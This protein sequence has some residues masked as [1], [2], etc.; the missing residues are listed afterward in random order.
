MTKVETNNAPQNDP[1]F[2]LHSFI[3]I[4]NAFSS[5]LSDILPQEAKNSIETKMIGD[6]INPNFVLQPR[7]TDIEKQK[8]SHFIKEHIQITVFNGD[9][10]EETM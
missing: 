10:T 1:S 4:V 3:D 9:T 8:R 5:N 7:L 2:Q 6:P